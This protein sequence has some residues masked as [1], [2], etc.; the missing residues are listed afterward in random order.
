[1]IAKVASPPTWV[2]VSALLNPEAVNECTEIFSD[3]LVCTTV[4]Y[5]ILRGGRNNDESESGCLH[6]YYAR[7]YFSERI[8]NEMLPF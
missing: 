8:L 7:Y 3:E 1:M 6:Y 5:N 4:I 2:Q